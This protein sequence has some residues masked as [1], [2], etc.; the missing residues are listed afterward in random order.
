MRQSIEI[1]A[2]IVSSLLV[3]SASLAPAE[4][5]SVE[6]RESLTRA[7]QGAWLP[8]ESGLAVGGREGTPLSGKYEIDDG[9]FQLSIYTSR[10]GPPSGEAFMEVIVDYSAGMVLKAVPIT[11]EG[12]LS[13]ARAQKEAM[14]RA[15][16]SLAEATAA[17]VKANAGYRAVSATPRLDNG[18]PVA[19][20]TLV[21][22]N[23]WKVVNERLD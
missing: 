12:D 7:I 19:E 3:T 22:G 15:K 14:D 18:Q 23:D 13:A 21:R 2:V 10:D 11:D 8:L 9:A 1:A 20:V 5:S 4:T 16:R 17:A 6:G